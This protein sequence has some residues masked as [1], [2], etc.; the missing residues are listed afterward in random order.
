MEQALKGIR[1]LDLSM[2]LPGPFMTWLMAQMGAEV[3]KVENPNGGDYGRNFNNL[4]SE[5]AMPFFFDLVNRGKKSIAIDLKQPKGKEAFLKLLSQYDIIVEGFR[6][7]VMQKLGINYETIKKTHPNIIYV[8]ITG[9]GQKGIYSQK[10]GHDINYQAL[11]GIFDTGGKPAVTPH[12]PTVLMADIA[13]GSLFGLTG[14]LAAI[15]ERYRTGKGQHIDISIYDCVHALSVLGFANM[16]AGKG[17]KSHGHHYLAGIHPFYNI[18]QT[19]DGRHMTLGAIEEKFWKNFCTTIQREGLINQ[20]YGGKDIVEE[21]AD[22]IKYRTQQEWI[23][24]FEE[25]DACF[26][27]VLSLEEVVSSDLSKSR[28]LYEKDS[29]GN[30]WLKTPFGDHKKP[31]GFDPPPVLGMDTRLVLINSGYTHSEIDSFSNESVIKISK[32]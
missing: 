14:L 4:D 28:K 31:G 5:A 26:E 23:D 22:I 27:P 2:Y 7:G 32:T 11:A 6:P 18:Y 16:L 24:A 20:Q 29:N 15:I 1:V 9:Y 12:V 17:K 19:K 3:V 13:G 10:G 8:S 21:V 30:F 25:V